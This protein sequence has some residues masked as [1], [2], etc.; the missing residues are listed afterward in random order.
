M[1]VGRL[2]E[3]WPLL[4]GVS[5]R[6][7]AYCIAVARE[8]DSEYEA[9][10]LPNWAV[11]EAHRLSDDQMKYLAYK[12]TER[13]YDEDAFYGAIAGV[14]RAYACNCEPICGR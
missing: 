4:M 3:E 13:L 7:V 14:Y 8:P 11:E 5:R 2:D 9:D 6:D 10:D 12:V 1:D